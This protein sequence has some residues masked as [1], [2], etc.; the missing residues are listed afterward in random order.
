MILSIRQ[1]YTSV[2]ESEGNQMKQ[3]PEGG[4][5]I[6]ILKNDYPEFSFLFYEQGKY[7]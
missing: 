5:I 4:K 6:Q 2:T 3:T 1:T 7:Y